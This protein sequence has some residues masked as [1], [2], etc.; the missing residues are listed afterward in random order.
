MSNFIHDNQDKTERKILADYWSD[1]YARAEPIMKPGVGQFGD[2]YP[3]AG[4]DGLRL[5]WVDL[6]AT[7][8]SLTDPDRYAAF[9]TEMEN[10]HE[11]METKMK[12][13][14]GLPVQDKQRLELTMKVEKAAM[15]RWEHWDTRS[16]DP[17]EKNV[18]QK[19][20]REFQKQ[21]GNL[22]EHDAKMGHPVADQ[23]RNLAEHPFTQEERSEWM[24]RKGRQLTQE[25]VEHRNQTSMYD[26]HSRVSYGQAKWVEREIG[27]GRFD[28][29]NA[30][31]NRSEPGQLMTQGDRIDVANLQQAK[32]VAHESQGINQNPGPVYEAEKARREKIG[33]NLGDID[34]KRGLTQSIAR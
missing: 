20:L 10:R 30:W 9:K 31:H 21:V 11:N 22:V 6:K 4:D 29:K 3:R 28:M 26:D 25:D 17:K 8:S 27:P 24:H 7:P 5:P 13:G 2:N 16:M 14:Y 12:P 34:R 23:S 1:R 18:A 15:D 32:W 33:I 19:S